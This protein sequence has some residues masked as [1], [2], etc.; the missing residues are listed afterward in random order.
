[1]PKA[2]GIEA[3]MPLTVAKSVVVH[4]LQNVCVAGVFTAKEVGHPGY[5]MHFDPIGM[6]VV[7]ALPNFKDEIPRVLCRFSLEL[8]LGV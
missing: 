5:R 4:V 6:V 7:V 8:L 1:M 3:R 2:V